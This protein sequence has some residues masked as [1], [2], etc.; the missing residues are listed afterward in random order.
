M[1]GSAWSFLFTPVLIGSVLIVVV[2]LRI[3]N[4]DKNRQYPK[5]WI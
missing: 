5:F 2:A 4:L 3:N 1:A